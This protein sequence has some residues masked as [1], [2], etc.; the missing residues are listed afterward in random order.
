MLQIIIPETELYNESTNEFIYTSEKKLQL[1]HS[2]ISISK[3]ESKWC[4][5]FLDDKEK[6][7]AEIRDYV[8][9]MT[10]GNADPDVYNY[11]TV[12]NYRDIRDYI[13]APMTATTFTNVNDGEKGKQIVTSELIYYWMVAYQ[14]PFECQKWHI[15]RLLTLIQICNVK[16]QPENKMSKS[17]I[18]QQNRALNEARKKRL[19]TKG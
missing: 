5:P 9:C 19:R 16:N 11:L 17:A 8:R 14:I 2:L 4:R 12:Q 18:M 7:R 10:L 1:E 6:T 13:D 15:N 3:W